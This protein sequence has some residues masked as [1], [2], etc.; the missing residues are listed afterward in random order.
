M[1]S[2]C[3]EEI[4]KKTCTRCGK[5]IEKEKEFEVNKSFDENKFKAL[6]GE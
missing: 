2:E 1:C 5:A 6:S 3:K 4:K